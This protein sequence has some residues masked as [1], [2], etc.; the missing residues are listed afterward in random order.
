[1]SD[2]I[3]AREKAQKIESQRRIAASRTP[4][5][6]AAFNEYHRQWKIRKLSSMSVEQRLALTKKETASKARRKIEMSDEQRAARK[7]YQTEW[8]ARHRAANRDMHR[9][10]KRELVKRLRAESP[11]FVLESRLRGR[12]KKAVDRHDM[13]E[14]KP[15]TMRLVGCTR[16]QLKTFIESKFKPGMTWENKHL[17]HIDHILPVSS[18]NLLDPA[19][20]Q[21]CFHFTNLQPLWA[22]ENMQKGN[23]I[24]T[25]DLTTKK[26][27]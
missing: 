21:A 23:R 27:A 20:M 2:F 26:A 1:M 11:E 15:S 7:K 8:M 19:Q 16:A 5:E 6:R 22:K 13:R 12:L 14:A 17:W 25:A 10:K 4:E 3:T 18:F 24:L 9:Q